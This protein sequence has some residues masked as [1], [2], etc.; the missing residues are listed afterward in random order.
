MQCIRRNIIRD[1]RITRCL[2]H[3]A[4][5]SMMTPT[6][7]SNHSKYRFHEGTQSGMRLQ[8]ERAE[9]WN[10]NKSGNCG[11]KRVRFEPDDNA[12][13]QFPRSRSHTEENSLG[14]LQCSNHQPSKTKASVEPKK[15]R[16]SDVA[17]YILG[18]CK[19]NA[20]S[21]CQDQR[22]VSSADL[23]KKDGRSCPIKDYVRRTSWGNHG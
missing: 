19:M 2:F 15:E 23:R 18:Y 17:E 13:C 1:V 16:V 10:M 4:I 6:R 11:E 3:H 5:A 9:H 8:P 20:F 22:E 14:T 21:I 12:S 7:A